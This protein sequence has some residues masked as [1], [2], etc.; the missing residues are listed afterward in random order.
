MDVS[1]L[2]VAIVAIITA[3]GAV[4]KQVYD[5]RQL[6]KWLCYRNPCNDRVS[7][8]DIKTA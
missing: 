3:I 6:K 5:T 8:D 1:T 2:S 7:H 4:I